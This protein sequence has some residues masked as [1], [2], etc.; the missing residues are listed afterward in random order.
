MILSSRGKDVKELIFANITYFENNIHTLRITRGLS[1][2]FKKQNIIENLSFLT[3]FLLIF[4][5]LLSAFSLRI[6]LQ[7]EGVSFH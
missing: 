6:I 2:D 7:Q 1:H 3:P 5:R 4:F